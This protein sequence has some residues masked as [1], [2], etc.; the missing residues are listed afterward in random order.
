MPA[1]DTKDIVGVP[2]LLYTLGLT[3]TFAEGRRLFYAKA[4]FVNDKLVENPIIRKPEPGDIVRVGKFK[5]ITVEQQSSFFL[6]AF[7]FSDI[8]FIQKEKGK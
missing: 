8:I 6:T 3:Q 4:V 7:S 2:E 1:L 5:S